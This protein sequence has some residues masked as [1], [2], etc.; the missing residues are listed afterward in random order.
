MNGFTWDD[1]WDLGFYAFPIGVGASLG[2]YGI[3]YLFGFA[4]KHAE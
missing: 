2:V 4:P 3:K 1:F